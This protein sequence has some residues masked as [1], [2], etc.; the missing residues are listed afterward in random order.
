M[1]TTWRERL[2]LGIAELLD[3]SLGELRSSLQLN[4]MV[5]LEWLLEAYA[6]YGQ[7]HKPLTVL[8]GMPGEPP[9]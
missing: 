6:V 9:R 8:H 4:Y 1:K 3:P 5:D 2:S 7:E